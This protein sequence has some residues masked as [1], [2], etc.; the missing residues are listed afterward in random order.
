MHADIPDAASLLS[1]GLL[2][3]DV[4][5]RRQGNL[6]AVGAQQSTVYVQDEGSE[7]V[8]PGLPACPLRRP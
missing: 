4:M 8:A 7:P 3:V 5:D 1:H 6:L 2:D